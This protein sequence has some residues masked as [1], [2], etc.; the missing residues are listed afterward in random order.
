MI[1]NHITLFC[2]PLPSNTA[3]A[4]YDCPAQAL[5]TKP[6]SQNQDTRPL[7]EPIGIIEGANKL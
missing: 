4:N 7:M 2:N 3:N 5:N 6:E 1:S